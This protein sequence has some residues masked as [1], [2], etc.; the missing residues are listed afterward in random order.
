MLN[1]SCFYNRINSPLHLERSAVFYNDMVPLA[2][3]I[4]FKRLLLKHKCIYEYLS[5][6]ENHS[7]DDSGSKAHSS[8]FVNTNTYG[9][10][11]F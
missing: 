10:L 1:I 7:Y 6:I 4:G 8:S 2:N 11:V 9:M 5:N 3:H